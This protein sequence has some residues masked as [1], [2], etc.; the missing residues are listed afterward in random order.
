MRR[1]ATLH[2]MERLV[3]ATGRRA[4]YRPRSRGRRAACVWAEQ[5]AKRI[6]SHPHSYQQTSLK[7]MQF[8]CNMRQN[9]AKLSKVE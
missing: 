6:F 7:I 8:S 9:P 4:I 2:A 5:P 3:R 1:G